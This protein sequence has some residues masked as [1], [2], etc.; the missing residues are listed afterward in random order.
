MGQASRDFGAELE[1]P[2]KKKLEQLEKLEV[3]AHFHKNQPG[4]AMIG[5]GPPPDFEPK[6]MRVAASGADFE[7]TLG[8]LSARPGISFGIEAKSVGPKPPKEGP[9]MQSFIREARMPDDQIKHLDALARAGAVSLLLLQWRPAD[10]PWFV[11]IIPWAEVPWRVAKVR[12]HLDMEAARAWRSGGERN[13]LA[14]HFF[15][16]GNRTLAA[17]KP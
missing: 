16:D 15:V 14:S 3:V 8:R 7:G 17:N 10:E 9:G 1:K 4:W 11:T 12:S 13:G 6:Y 2:V 5:K